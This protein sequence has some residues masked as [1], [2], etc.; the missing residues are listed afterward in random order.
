[1]QRLLRVGDIHQTMSHVAFRR[2]PGTGEHGPLHKR[3]GMPFFAAINAHRKS[4][5]RH[6]EIERVKHPAEHQESLRLGLQQMRVVAEHLDLV[7]VGL[8]H[9]RLRRPNGGGRRLAGH[10]VDR[11]IPNGG[12]VLLLAQMR[13]FAAVGNGILMIEVGKQRKTSR[14]GG[15]V[16]PKMLAILAGVEAV[17]VGD[18]LLVEF[19]DRQQKFGAERFAVLAHIVEHVAERL[20]LIRPDAG[21][22]P[23]R[24]AVAGIGAEI[25]K[26]RLVHLNDVDAQGVGLVEHRAEELPGFRRGGAQLVGMPLPDVLLAGCGLVE[27]VGL[28]LA[29]RGVN[30][31]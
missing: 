6:V 10:Q 27:H 9:D 15:G 22:V 12:V 30:H 16:I 18:H 28:G 2:L 26:G 5:R 14:A 3:L 7:R 25:A 1:M 8:G 19:L 29:R 23:V 11:H 13:A 4:D 21:L 24:G 17:E 20:R 31:H